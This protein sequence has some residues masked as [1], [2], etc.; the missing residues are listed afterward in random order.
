MEMSNMYGFL[1]NMWI[2]GK[3]D[4]DYLIAQ[5]AKRRITEEEKA[6]ILATPQI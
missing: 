2:M 4:E 3:I 6:M 5:V 1:L